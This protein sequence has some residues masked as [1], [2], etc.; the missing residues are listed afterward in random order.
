MVKK[1]FRIV[2][3][4]TEDGIKLKADYF[5]G[6]HRS[7]ILL[8]MLNH[9]RRDWKDLAIRLQQRNFTVIAPDFRGHGDSEGNWMAFKEREFKNMEFD[10][11]AAVKFLKTKKKQEISVIGASIG[12]NLA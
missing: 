6:G 3:L 5:E 1:A 9:D 10:V 12:A 2:E 4:K 11:D 7:V 8:H